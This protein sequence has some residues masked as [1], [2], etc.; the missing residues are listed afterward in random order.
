MKYNVTFCNDKP[1]KS[2]NRSFKKEGVVVRKE[3]V[4]ISLRGAI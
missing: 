3:I 1:S 4:V 2:K